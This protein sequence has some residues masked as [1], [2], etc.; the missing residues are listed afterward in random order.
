MICE[1]CGIDFPEAKKRIYYIATVDYHLIDA[2]TVEE[3][4][5]GD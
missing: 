1:H 3:L 5:T 4:L 2:P